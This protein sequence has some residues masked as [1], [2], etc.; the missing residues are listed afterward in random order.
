MFL[1]GDQRAKIKAM[2]NESQRLYYREHRSKLDPMLMDE[3]KTTQRDKEN[4]ERIR[5]E[6]DG[7]RDV[8]R[9]LQDGGAL[10]TVPVQHSQPLVAPGLLQVAE[11]L[12]GEP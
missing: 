5:R 3:T 8:A 12:P 6:M 2:S 1:R 7:S 10:E 9:G 11:G 4:H